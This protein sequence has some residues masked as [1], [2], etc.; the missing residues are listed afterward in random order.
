VHRIE[1]A[2][3]RHSVLADF[4]A[5]ELERQAAARIKAGE[6]IA[7][8]PQLA[9]PEFIRVQPGEHIDSGSLVTGEEV[10]Q[11]MQAET[12]AVRKLLPYPLCTRDVC[13]NGCDPPTRAT[14]ESIAGD[15]AASASRVWQESGG[16]VE[17]LAPIAQSLR[18]ASAGHLQTGYCGAVHLAAQ[19]YALHV[20]RSV[21][22]RPQIRAAI[23]TEGQ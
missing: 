7:R 5:D 10:A 21:D 18:R 6:A 3:D 23:E 22:I 13:T 12:I 17:A 20:R 4:E 14:G 2:D 8:W 1:S 15:L 11:R 16:T 9:E 19:G